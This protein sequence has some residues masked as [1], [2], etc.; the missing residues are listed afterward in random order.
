[1]TETDKL[2]KLMR[3]LVIGAVA[4]GAIYVVFEAVL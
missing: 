1:M 4:I 2:L 3:Y